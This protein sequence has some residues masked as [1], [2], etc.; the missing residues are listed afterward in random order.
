MD[1]GI[2][3]SC[4]DW[5]LLSS[6][7]SDGRCWLFA[8][9]VAQLSNEKEER[10]C[11]WSTT[12][13]NREK[14]QLGWI[15]ENWIQLEERRVSR[16]LR[17]SGNKGF[18]RS[19]K[20]F[21]DLIKDTNPTVWKMENDSSTFQTKRK[22]DLFQPQSISL[23]GMAQLCLISQEDEANAEESFTEEGERHHHKRTN[24]YIQGHFIDLISR[25]DYGI[26][27]VR[28]YSN[29]LLPSFH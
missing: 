6:L 22:D 10:T 21:D 1:G 16:E 23:K 17:R 18:D 9:R 29:Y 3:C 14:Q 26:M 4:V 12:R 13:N 15:E 28:K 2:V 20:W 27:G 11:C 25:K 7:L 24:Q 5:D 8:A 19:C